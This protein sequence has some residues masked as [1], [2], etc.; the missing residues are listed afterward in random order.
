M[1]RDSRR[2]APVSLAA[3]PPS[4]I[5]VRDLAFDYAGRRA[6]RDVSFEI[7]PAT[8]TALV[9]PNGAGKTTLLKCLAALHRPLSGTLAVAGIDV[10]AE[11]RAVHRAIGFLPDFYGLYDALTVDQ[12]LRYFAAAHG[13]PAALRGERIRSTARALGIEDRLAQRARSLSRGLRQRLAIAQAIV[14]DPPVL[15]LDEP[16]AGLDPDARAELSALLRGFRAS[17]K[18]I[19]VSSHIL[20]ELEDYSSHML[21]LRDG[22]IVDHGPIGGSAA[23]AAVRRLRLGLAEPALD[24]ATVLA[25][26]LDGGVVTAADSVTAEFDFPGDI[27]A[28]HAL[29]RKLLDA[30]LAI[31]SFEEVR[32]SMQDIYLDRV[33]DRRP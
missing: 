32:R 14:H 10:L 17:A 12:C 19:I 16:A 26:L 22:S 18:T 3:R 28:Q 1:R 27:G 7:A 31:A 33:H 21:I 15:L 29:L 25:A 4:A 30:G 9:G 24:L 8:I 13:V 2:V 11:P 23:P 6:L 5:A 20:S